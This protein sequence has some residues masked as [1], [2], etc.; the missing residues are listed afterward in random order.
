MKTNTFYDYFSLV[1]PLVDLFFKAQK[2]VLATELNLLP[3]GEVLEI[4]IGDASQTHLLK[5]HQITGIDTSE[6]MLAKAKKRKLENLKLMLMDAN[7]LDFK[8]NS[9]DYVI[10]SHVMSVV[11]NPTEILNEASRVL[12]PKGKI[13]IL[14]HF[15]PNNSLKHLDIFFNKFSKLFHFKS[16][17]YKKDL[18][19]ID[20]LVLEKEI[21][22]G[23]YSY[24]KLL[25]YKKIESI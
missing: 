21:S 10:L 18:E 13:F 25:I 8:E 1:Y 9:F 19:I 17:Y 14:N 4:G 5:T 11:K 3:K 16:L 22:F 15:T 7:N 24:Y 20:N 2:K 12:K 6:K 23:R